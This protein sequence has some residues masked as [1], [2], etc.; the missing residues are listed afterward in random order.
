MAVKIL[1]LLLCVAR[2][3]GAVPAMPSASH[4][5]AAGTQQFICTVNGAISTVAV[6]AAA[7]VAVL[8]GQYD[9]GRTSSNLNETILNTANVVQSLFSPSRFG[10]VFTRAVDGDIYAQPLYVSNVNIRGKGIRNV[11]YVATMH[12][13]IY[14]FDADNP[15]QSAP[16]WQVNLGPSVPSV[17]YY[18]NDIAPEVGILST[19]VIDLQ[20]NTIYAVANTL[21]DT[22][23]S[24]SL[25]ALDIVTGQEKAGGAVVI[26]G[27]LPGSGGGSVDGR[28]EFNAVQHLQRP[29]LLLLDGVIYI[30]FGSHGDLPPYHGWLFG[31]SAS[32]ILQQVAG[33]IVTPDGDQGSIWQS[34]RG[35]AADSSG[36][37]YV[38]TA[39]GDYDGVSNL[40]ES[41][42]K[43][44]TASGLSVADWFT[45]D[46]WAGMNAADD[47]L[48]SV[49][50]MLLP[51]ANALVAAGKQGR[52]YLMNRDRLGH[53]QTGNTQ[54][55]QNFQAAQ[56][57]IYS[58]A[59]WNNSNGPL[60]YVWGWAD[61][62]YSYA[63]VQGQFLTARSAQSLFRT[64]FPGGILALSANG[65]A[66]GSGIL[67]AT[68][69]NTE[70]RAGTGMLHAF[71]AAD[72][73]RELWNS[74]KDSARDRLGNF[75]KFN[76]PTVANGKVYVGT[77]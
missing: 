57:G 23:Y 8:T 67:W 69:A 31:Y 42:I 72:I 74:E 44:S 24:Y 37:I 17:N 46:N 60:L 40:G 77:F 19:P 27:N 11:V 25:H 35:P 45:P 50:P 73:S 30:A 12:N 68:R 70:T 13:T 47:D 22:I 55:T 16:L 5:A 51:G 71:D 32:N 4:L 43:F 66:P 26:S 9:N 54:I 61:Y 64:G 52:I 49:G 62:L 29:A 28:I 75:T 39:N 2:V 1:G 3:W 41:V 7:P 15:T 53:L 36:N 33:Y 10:K 6:S 58:M 48:G 21:E 20:T 76:T 38:E 63:M 65:S 14:A 34:G 56:Y 59:F 18:T